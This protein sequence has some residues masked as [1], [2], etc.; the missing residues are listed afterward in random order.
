[1]VGRIQS[2]MLCPLVQAVVVNLTTGLCSGC[3]VGRFAL[4]SDQKWSSESVSG[5]FSTGQSSVAGVIT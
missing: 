1:M 2:S 3:L 5:Q 4:I